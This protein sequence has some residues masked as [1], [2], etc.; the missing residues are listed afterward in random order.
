ME[1]LERRLVG[2]EEKRAVL[3]IVDFGDTHGTTHG[4]AELVLAEGLSTCSE[5][6]ASVENVVAQE[7]ERRPVQLVGAGLGDDVDLP[8]GSAPVL[9]TERERHDTE[10]LQ[11]IRVR[12][13]MSCIG[14]A[15][16]S[17]SAIQSVVVMVPRVPLIDVPGLE[18]PDSP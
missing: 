15:I 12:H 17:V 8:A 4:H 18:P 7:F 13:G 6:A 2:E 10:L 9:R 16:D 14:E 5:E 3:A 1:A 11:C